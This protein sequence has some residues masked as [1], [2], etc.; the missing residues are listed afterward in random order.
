MAQSGYLIARPNTRATPGIGMS[1]SS[2][3]ILRNDHER[4]SIWK[5]ISKSSKRSVSGLSSSNDDL[6]DRRWP[7]NVVVT[8]G[9][10]N[11]VETPNARAV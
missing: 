3:K 11:E 4:N 6:V 9:S 8:L 10:E 2:A 1:I 5:G 7:S